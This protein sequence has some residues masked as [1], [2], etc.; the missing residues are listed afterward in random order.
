MSTPKTEPRRTLIHMDAD[1][2]AAWQAVDAQYA[3][4]LAAAGID[5]ALWP[6]PDPAET[7]HLAIGPDADVNASA[8]TLLSECLP[9]W[10]EMWHLTAGAA[11]LAAAIRTCIPDLA[12][13]VAVSALVD[14]IGPADPVQ[15]ARRAERV[16]V[17]HAAAVILDAMDRRI[18]YDAEQIR[19]GHGPDATRSMVVYRLA[20]GLANYEGSDHA[21]ADLLAVANGTTDPD[22]T[23]QAARFLTAAARTTVRGLFGAWPVDLFLV[24]AGLAAGTDAV[25]HAVYMDRIYH[26]EPP[27]MARIAAE[28]A[29]A[30]T[31]RMVW[32][33]M[34]KIGLGHMFQAD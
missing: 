27:G 17:A 22:G 31:A 21:A 10:P 16:Q 34:D 28:Q 8:A 30:D 9:T 29:H 11:R 33:E 5:R 32:N 20:L 2:A 15:A 14:A 19:K 12:P 13:G 24:R 6:A 26:A 4:H 18:D 23:F 3:D 7:D 1:M 25:W